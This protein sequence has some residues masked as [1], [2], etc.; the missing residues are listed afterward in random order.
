MKWKRKRNIDLAVLPSHNTMRHSVKTYNL[1]E[2][3]P[4]CTTSGEY[5]LGVLHQ[6]R[7]PN[8]LHYHS[9]SFWV[10]YQYRYLLTVQVHLSCLCCDYNF[11][12]TLFPAHIL[13]NI[14][15]LVFVHLSLVLWLWGE[16]T[17]YSWTTFLY[18]TYLQFYYHFR[19]L[20]LII[21]VYT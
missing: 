19:S 16:N 4:E 9:I 6:S 13:H 17:L 3:H 11:A 8:Q 5:W 2:P 14:I 18:S 10:L 21:K 15:G 12:Y 7:Q 1:T 20:S